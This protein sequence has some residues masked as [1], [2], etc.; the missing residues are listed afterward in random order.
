MNSL[1]NE[2]N[3]CAHQIYNYMQDCTIGALE[4]FCAIK[5]LQKLLDN[6]LSEIQEKANEIYE[7]LD[8]P[9]TVSGYVLRSYSP[10]TKYE[11][12]SEKTE[13]LKKEY[14]TSKRIDE[15]TGVATKKEVTSKT[16]FTV[17]LN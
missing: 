11:N 6:R 5:H 8:N 3:D 10:P 14:E 15:L 16:K 1:Q 17:V 4:E 7:L 12:Y 9:K 2:I 13:A